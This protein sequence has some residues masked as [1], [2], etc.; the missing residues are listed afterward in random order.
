MAGGILDGRLTGMGNGLAPRCEGAELEGDIGPRSDG[1]PCASLPTFEP[2][3]AGS[4]HSPRGQAWTLLWF[5][6]GA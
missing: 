3:G 5:A 4:F 6:P 1:S 2:Q